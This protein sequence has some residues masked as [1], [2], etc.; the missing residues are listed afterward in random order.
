MSGAESSPKPPPPAEKK[1]MKKRGSIIADA[2]ESLPTPKATPDKKKSVDEGEINELKEKSIVTRRSSSFN[3]GEMAKMAQT[4]P[5]KASPITH[6]DVAVITQAKGKREK[7]KKKEKLEKHMEKESRRKSRVSEAQEDVA[8][9][10]VDIKKEIARRSSAD[11]S[12]EPTDKKFQ[13]QR[14]VSAFAHALKRDSLIEDN[15][16]GEQYK[17]RPAHTPLT[18][19]L[20]LAIG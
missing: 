11:F 3:T 17:V 8:K 2:K 9:G 1:K 12:S 4:P 13:R 7:E 16:H 15:L 18:H 20:S 5:P 19:S 6:S 14:E 10:A